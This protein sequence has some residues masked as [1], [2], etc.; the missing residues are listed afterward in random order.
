MVEPT[1]SPKFKQSKVMIDTKNMLK[2]LNHQLK[3]IGLVD[4]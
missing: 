1:L 3:E 2:D 4:P